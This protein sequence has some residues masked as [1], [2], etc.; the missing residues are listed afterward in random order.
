VGGPSRL[1]LFSRS[2]GRGQC[3]DEGLA[4]FLASLVIV[5][6]QGVVSSGHDGAQSPSTA[7]GFL[8]YH[9]VSYFTVDGVWDF[10]RNYFWLDSGSD[11]RIVF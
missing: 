5:W 1:D 11:R 2:G 7:G 8:V 9:G 6:D 4:S 10:A 3:S